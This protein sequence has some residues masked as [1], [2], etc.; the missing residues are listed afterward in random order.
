M[1]TNGIAEE[2]KVTPDEVVRLLDFHAH[3]ADIF[4]AEQH[5]FGHEAAEQMRRYRLISD[6]EAV[7]AAMEMLNTSRHIRQL[8]LCV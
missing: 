5:R 1:T 4:T 7:I 6:Y 2:L 3:D 8:D